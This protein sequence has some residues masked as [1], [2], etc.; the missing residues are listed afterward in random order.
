M[1]I[2]ELFPTLDLPIKANS[3]L[4]GAGHFVWSELLIKKRAFFN[5]ALF[6]CKGK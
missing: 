6:S 5:M 3:G 1:L 4:V 2:S